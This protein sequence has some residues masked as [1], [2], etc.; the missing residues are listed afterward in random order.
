MITDVQ[1][2]RLSKQ[3]LIERFLD[4]LIDPMQ[5]VDR[6]GRS[7]LDDLEHIVVENH[8]F[9]FAA[10]RFPDKEAQAWFERLRGELGFGKLEDLIAHVRAHADELNIANLRPRSTF[11]NETLWAS[12]SSFHKLKEDSSVERITQF[13][14]DVSM[15]SIVEQPELSIDADAFERY[16]RTDRLNPWTYLIRRE[17]ARGT[18]SADDRVICI[19]N[20]WA[21]EILY[22]R[23]TLGLRN[24]IGVDLISTNPELIVAADMHDLPFADESIK[25]VFTRGTINK[26]YD[27][28]LFVSEIIRVL[29]KDGLVAVETVGPFD[30]GV[31]RLSLTDV[32]H[33]RN[34]LRLFRG[35]VKKIIYADAQEPY[36][37]QD[38][39]SR[40][41][42][43]FIQL[44]KKR[45]TTSPIRESDPVLRL[46]IHEFIRGY[47]LG[48]RR[49]MR[50][51]VSIVR[52]R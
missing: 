12:E 29:S 39:G 14:R 15:H 19:G 5:C 18:L 43:L 30:Y 13:Q 3:E 4:Y 25:M 7:Y 47:V 49:K 23:Q 16:I 36:A 11:H 17:V 22:F 44:D 21:G 52:R 26:S 46:K 38:G 24:A 8:H 28:R 45:Q 41:V 40:L 2:S 27:V 34:L 48:L 6:F 51:A 9:D 31:S 33:W 32:K 35:K 1:T 20:R 10:Q 50:R 37:Y 42:R